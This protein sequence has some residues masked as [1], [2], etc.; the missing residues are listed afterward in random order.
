MTIVALIGLFIFSRFGRLQIL[1]LGTPVLR[2]GAWVGLSYLI[3]RLIHVLLD[4]RDKRLPA[5]PAG[6]LAAYALFPPALVAGPIHRANDFVPQL[7]LAHHPESSRQVADCLWRIGLG[8]FKK[9]VLANGLA[10]FALNASMVYNP[11]L[12]RGVL[13]LA[14][15]AY[16][17]MLYFDFSGYSDIAIGAA[18]LMGIRLPENF[19]N[20]YVQPN[21]A[22]FWQTWHMTLSTWLR[23]YLFFP[24]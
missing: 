14:V 9:L 3:F 16:T 12:P 4:Y 6:D 7:D 5:I 10:L 17:F 1:L 24:L 13:W 11:L 19:A 21:I 20:P 8:A 22:R 15:I 23:D 18:G 2:R